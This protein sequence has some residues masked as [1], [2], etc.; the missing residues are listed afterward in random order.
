MMGW[1]QMNENE[2]VR[3]YISSS[4]QH[5]LAGGCWVLA[6]HSAHCKH[7]LY[8]SEI[9]HIIA[10]H[11]TLQQIMGRYLLNIYNISSLGNIYFF[12]CLWSK[13]SGVQMRPSLVHILSCP[14][15]SMQESL[16]YHECVFSVY[17]MFTN[18]MRGRRDMD[19]I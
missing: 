8:L 19:S 6:G 18:H 1:R 11:D 5:I 9:F 7:C 12:K 13:D 10:T 15:I 16:I 3:S 17:E 2:R 4:T 14:Q